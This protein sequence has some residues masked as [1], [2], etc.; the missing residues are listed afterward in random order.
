MA[1][2][3]FDMRGLTA[4]YLDAT[5]PDVQT[6][7]R[8]GFVVLEN[9]LTP[10]QI[11]LILRQ[12]HD[13]FA[14]LRPELAP[15][16]EHSKA[17]DLTD[18]EYTNGKIP[19]SSKGL[20]PQLGSGT[21]A[22]ATMARAFVVDA[23]MALYK[24]EH[25]ANPY[26]SADAR[27][28]L[29][30]AQLAA[31]AL[32]GGR[33]RAYPDQSDWLH[34]DQAHDEDGVCR[35]LQAIIYLTDT[36]PYGLRTQV[37]GPREGQTLQ[38]SYD[39]HNAA[40]PKPTAKYAAQRKLERMRAAGATEAELAAATAAAAVEAE[41]EHRN[42]D[43]TDAER[44]HIAEHC[45]VHSGPIKAGSVLVWPSGAWH[46]N[47]VFPAPSKADYTPVL[48]M[49]S[50]FRPNALVDAAERA[51]LVEMY[52]KPGTMR[53]THHRPTEPSAAL[54]QARRDGKPAASIGKRKPYIQ[55]V[56]PVWEHWDVPSLARDKEAAAALKA[57][58]EARAPTPKDLA[59]YVRD[60]AAYVAGLAWPLSLEAKHTIEFARLNL[61]IPVPTGEAIDWFA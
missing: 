39:A 14:T 37:V 34:R 10:G 61:A 24:P 1:A 57:S 36:G 26:G 16:A 32:A 46:A 44:A 35:D 60:P 6:L 53:S 29:T 40:F 54:R 58:M 2:A 49:I 52:T 25:R 21:Y 22:S 43:C 50:T 51:A 41:K 38:E 28:F 19:V 20:S 47:I 17:H 11:E 5:N 56:H 27:S 8:Q 9:V 13:E 31:M 7:A 30:A 18:F 15:A 59:A 33:H 42:S 4:P 45:V 55:R 12:A 3:A 23:I 48:R